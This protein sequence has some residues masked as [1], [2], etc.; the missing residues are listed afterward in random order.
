VTFSG[1]ELDG[2]ADPGDFGEWMDFSLKT[3]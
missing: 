3:K 1:Q 2:V